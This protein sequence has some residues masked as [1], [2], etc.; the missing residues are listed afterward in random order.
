MR[1]EDSEGIY[2][3]VDTGYRLLY[4]ADGGGSA[5]AA[6]AGTEKISAVLYVNCADY[7]CDFPDAFGCRAGPAAG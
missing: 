6:G 2:L 7:S 1:G 5:C 3:W 4:A